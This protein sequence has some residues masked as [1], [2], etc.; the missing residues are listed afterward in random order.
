MR[1]QE[2]VSLRRPAHDP[3]RQA[4]HRDG[5]QEERT[6]DQSAQGEGQ[7]NAPA[8]PTKDVGAFHGPPM[9]TCGPVSIDLRR[10]KRVE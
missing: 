10:R 2:T 5:L 8:R 4:D 6:A 9:R 1:H 3:T 7:V